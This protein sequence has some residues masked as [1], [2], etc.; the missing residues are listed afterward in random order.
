MKFIVWKKKSIK[1][2]PMLVHWNNSTLKVA[3]TLHYKVEHLGYHSGSMSDL[4]GHF[5]TD[6]QNLNI[7]HNEC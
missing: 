5:K 3:T 4:L 1:V 7:N 6:P 2:Q